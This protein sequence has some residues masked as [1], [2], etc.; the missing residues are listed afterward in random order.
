MWS[1]L[2]D[3][4][5]LPE[6]VPNL[7]SCVQEPCGRSGRKRLRQRGCSQSLFWRLEAEAVL[8]VEETETG[9]GQREIRF[10]IVEGDFKV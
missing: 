9:G 2:T 7:E 10:N 4:E 5:R 6:F 3:Y 1:V 8:E